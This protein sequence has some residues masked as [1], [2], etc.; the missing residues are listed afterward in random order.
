[1]NITYVFFA[2]QPKVKALSGLIVGRVKGSKRVALWH[3]ELLYQKG[4]AL[5]LFSLCLM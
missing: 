2:Q 1:M 4:V 3:K 5:R